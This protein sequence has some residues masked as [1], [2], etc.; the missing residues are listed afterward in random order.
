MKTE[1]EQE[2][3]LMCHKASKKLKED[4]TSIMNSKDYYAAEIEFMTLESKYKLA[5]RKFELLKDISDFV[6]G[7]NS[8]PSGRFQVEVQFLADG[9]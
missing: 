5:K 7:K 3:L 8:S 4:L 6:S 9:D 2:L 1:R